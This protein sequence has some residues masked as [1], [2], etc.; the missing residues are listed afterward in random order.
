M[1]GFWCRR[2]NGGSAISEC[3]TSHC[4]KRQT[5]MS[6]TA[7][8]NP[9]HRASFTDNPSQTYHTHSTNHTNPSYRACHGIQMF[10]H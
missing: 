2:N 3:I 5:D 6:H 10:E 1:T 8:V 9:T 4:N 7:H